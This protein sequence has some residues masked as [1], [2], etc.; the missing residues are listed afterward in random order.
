MLDSRTHNRK[1]AI[2]R[3]G[4]AGIVGGGMNVQHSLHLQY[5]N[6]V[7]LSKARRRDS[8]LAYNLISLPIKESSG[9]Y[10]KSDLYLFFNKRE[11][12]AILTDG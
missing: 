6:E 3:L 12:T 7:P 4:P 11:I 9:N 1:V 10:K 2:S 8:T 5:H